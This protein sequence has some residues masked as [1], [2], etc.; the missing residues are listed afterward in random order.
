[1]HEAFKRID[2]QQAAQQR[3]LFFGLQWLAVDAA[4]DPFA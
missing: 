1:M 3:T 4:F 2:C